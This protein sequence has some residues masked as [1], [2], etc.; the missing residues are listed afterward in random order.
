MKKQLG[1]LSLVYPIPIVLVGADVGGKTNFATVGDCCVMGLKPALVAISLGQAHH[2]TRG[3]EEHRAFSINFPSRNHL[4]LTDYCGMVSG[5]DV[6]KSA[7]F[8]VLRGELGVPIIEQCPVNLECRVVDEITVAHRHLF[9][10][11]VVQTH[12][13]EHLIEYQDGRPRVPDMRTLDPIIYA[14]DNRYYAIG[15]PIGVG[16]HEGKKHLADAD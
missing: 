16:Y 14:L 6:D 2:T 5:R 15:E 4:S 9:V 1:P 10:A 7:L 3:V 11:E 13:D 12:I 8:A